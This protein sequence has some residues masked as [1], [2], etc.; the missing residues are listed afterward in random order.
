MQAGIKA[1][2]IGDDLV[3]FLPNPIHKNFFIMI[4]LWKKNIK[5]SYS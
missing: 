1:L 4:D 3:N 2:N 5:N